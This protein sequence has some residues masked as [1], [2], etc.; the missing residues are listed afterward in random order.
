MRSLTLFNSSSS[1]ALGGEFSSLGGTPAGRLA[2][3]APNGTFDTDLNGSIG[4]GFNGDVLAML[5]S[6]NDLY[7]GGA[8][9][10]VA[11]NSQ[12][13][14]VKLTAPANA[15]GSSSIVDG[16]FDTST[17]GVLNGD[18]RALSLASDNSGQIFAAGAFTQYRGSNVP[19]VTRINTNGTIDTSFNTGAGFIANAGRSL[20]INTLAVTPSTGGAYSVYI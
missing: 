6:G 17:S 11:G 15:D 18:V 13:R 9:S 1:I 3:F 14:L 4:T 12:T 8:F 19:G 20:S 5:F 2:A 10:Q 16:T 7:L